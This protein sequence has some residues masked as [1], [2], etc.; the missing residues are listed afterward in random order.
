M[1]ITGSDIITPVLPRVQTGAS[2]LVT[3][4]P[5]GHHPWTAATPSRSTNG[6][7]ASYWNAFLLQKILLNIWISI[8]LQT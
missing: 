2:V 8:T 1:S 6:R 4:P 7:Y 3:V 5:P